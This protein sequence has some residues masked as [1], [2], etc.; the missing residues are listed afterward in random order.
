MFLVFFVRL[1]KTKNALLD[2]L[3]ITGFFLKNGGEYDG[4][5]EC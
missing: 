5:G 2:I 1:K 3:E 4:F